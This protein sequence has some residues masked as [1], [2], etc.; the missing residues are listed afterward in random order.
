MKPELTGCLV[1]ATMLFSSVAGAFDNEPDG[2]R[3]I[4]WGAPFSAHAKELTLVEKGKDENY[5]LRKGDK[6]SIGGAELKQL[7]YGYWKD[8]FVSVFIETSGAGNKSAL[9]EAFRSQFG[10]GYKPNQFMDEFLWRGATTTMSVKCS[11]IGEKCKAF[12]FSTELTAKQS[13]EKKKAAAG[14]AKDF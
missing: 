14:A 5:Y 6:M 1:G 7:A 2:F 4:K 10:S 8:Q 11:P 9:L 12:L 3:G 13:E